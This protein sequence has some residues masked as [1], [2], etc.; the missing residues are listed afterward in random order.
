MLSKGVNAVKFLP[1]ARKFPIRAKLIGMKDLSLIHIYLG[2]ALPY[3][4]Y[5]RT[6]YEEP[7][8]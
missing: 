5:G 1:P 6:R 8:V 3:S 4:G 2:Q 7:Q